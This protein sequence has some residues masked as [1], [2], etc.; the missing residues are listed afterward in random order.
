MS[1]AAAAAPVTNRHSPCIGVC[2]LDAPTGWCEG[3]GR[4]GVEIAGWVD[5][6]DA[7]RLNIFSD[8][9]ERL[10]RLG[11]E[12]RVLPWTGE[13]VDMIARR[14]AAGQ[15]RWSVG[16]PSTARI[17]SFHAGHGAAIER[18]PTGLV[19]R[20]AGQALALGQHDKLRGFA[21]VPD[22]RMIGLGLPMG[23]AAIPP[24]NVVTD[25]GADARTLEGGVGHLYDLGLG[26]PTLRLAIRPHDAGMAAVLDGLVGQPG[27]V[28]V[29]TLAAH[30][31][32]A[33]LV[34]VAETVLTRLE[35]RT[36]GRELAHL[37]AGPLATGSR[38]ATPDGL[39][40]AWAAPM[41]FGHPATD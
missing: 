7:R 14:I 40:P 24:V 18:S 29:S 10:T 26:G 13:I 2:R 22:D 38:V 4:T 9:P 3:C 19:T 25:L 31:G 30:T 33:P 1:V 23:R 39:V 21:D 41:L 36:S 12:T 35:T 16:R 27:D 17:L 34:A 37:L 8:L 15:C 5:A 28:A 6:D 32:D 11:A 20:S